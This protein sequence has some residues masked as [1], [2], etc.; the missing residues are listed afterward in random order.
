MTT[1]TI[2]VTSLSLGAVTANSL[3]PT[4]FSNQAATVIQQSSWT[5]L[6]TKYLCSNTDASFLLKTLPADNA[7]D[8]EVSTW[9]RLGYIYLR[10]D[11]SGNALYFVHSGETANGS[12]QIGIVTGLN[13]SSFP[14]GTYY[15]LYENDDL[16]HT[17]SGYSKSDTTG[18]VLT[19]GCSGFD[20][21]AKF[22]G[23]EFTRFKDY[24]QMSSGAVALKDQGVEGYGFRSITWTT[25]ADASLFSDYTHQKLDLRDWG[26][27]NIQ[28]TGSIS[29][30]SNSLVCNTVENWKVGD[31]AV[32]E[33]GAEP[34]LGQRGTV[35]VGGTWPILSYA[36]LTAMNADSGQIPFTFAW[37]RDNG[38]VYQ[39]GGGF[40]FYLSSFT[41]SLGDQV[42]YNGANYQ[43]LIN[44]NANNQPDISP[45]AW[46]VIA[47]SGVWVPIDPVG[48]F[49]VAQAIPKSIHGRISAISG[50]GT[51]L[52]LLQQPSQ[53]AGHIT[54]TTLTIDSGYVGRVA[55]GQALWGPG[56]SAGTTITGG[57]GTSW[58][59]NNSQTVS[60]VNMFTTAPANAAVSV[61]NANVYLDNQPYYNYLTTGPKFGWPS[62]LTNITPTGITLDIPT[63]TYAGT[64]ILQGAS[65]SGWTIKGQGQA[66]TFMLTPKGTCCMEFNNVLTD[67]W[68]FKDMTFTGNAGNQK[69]GLFFA[70]WTRIPGGVDTVGPWAGLATM[71][72]GNDAGALAEDSIPQGAPFPGAFLIDSCV[73]TV[74]Q[75]V[76]VN[77]V[78][79]KA[80]GVSYG[81]NVWA[82]R[83]TNNQSFPL[84]TYVQ[85]LFQWANHF[86]GGFVD[87]V[88]NSVF[89]QGGFESFECIG[90]Q[91]I[92]PVSV[93][94]SFSQNTSNAWL[95]KDAKLT[96]TA[97]NLSYPG[98][99]N[100]FNPL[101]N[102]NSNIGNQQG[103]LNP[104]TQDGGLID[105]VQIN[106]LGYTSDQ[107]DIP[108]GIVI[109]E[110]NPNVTVR[111]GYF[112]APDYAAPSVLPGPQGV[113]STGLNTQVIQFKCYGAIG[114]P[115]TT[116]S[117]ANIGVLTGNVYRCS[118]NLTVVG[119]G[120][121]VS[122]TDP[123]VVGLRMKN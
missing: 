39:F 4:H 43:S 28:T 65:A 105:N 84:Q 64:G 26:F 117:R 44:N 75:D 99:W 15:P 48:S 67:N 79:Q 115:D 113:R 112:T 17:I 68:L 32:V 10:V 58:T 52:T 2:D 103:Q 109:N 21:Y 6:N 41:Y 47:N 62:D 37:R 93:N 119:T 80:V 50:G 18:A 14:G 70:G 25:F 83:C 7:R 82:Y 31:W 100:K 116:I 123:G 88:V 114:S 102:I 85:W 89:I 118:T 42:G 66:N 86:G 53:F 90:H 23:V 54:G 55:V 69:F 34:G 20:I 51:T 8:V 91:M 94:G 49:Y 11:G 101:V 104:A 106:V 29:S 74:V 30:G 71:N 61:T 73:N 27:R 87:C 97:S 63:G 92:R 40:Q 77:D 9:M 13:E 3:S 33:I 59:V 57:S 72:L 98:N 81:S 38:A 110:G 121:T 46:Q 35:G 16:V 76:T 19:F 122:A 24:R 22:N 45:S 36:N 60:I 12:I 95:I 108:A 56:V 78:W 1:A 111:N 96:V 5:P 107:N 120:T